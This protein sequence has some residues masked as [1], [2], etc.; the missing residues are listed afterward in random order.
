MTPEEEAMEAELWS[1]FLGPEPFADEPD[2]W[3]DEPPGGTIALLSAPPCEVCGE[4]GACMFDS[5]GR[6][7]IHTRDEEDDD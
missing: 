4:P 2:S 5:E 6:P 1:R 7:L 3:M